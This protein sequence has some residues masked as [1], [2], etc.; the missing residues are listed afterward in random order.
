MGGLMLTGGKEELT[1]W[2]EALAIPQIRKFDFSFQEHIERLKKDIKDG[3]TSIV[4]EDWMLKTMKVPH[5]P[6]K[7]I[8]DHGKGDPLAKAIVIVQTSWFVLQCIARHA[9]GLT[10][11]EIELV[12]LAF[13]ALNVITYFLW[14]NKPL[15][16][17][18]PIYINMDGKRVDGPQE[19]SNQET[20]SREW[21]IGIETDWLYDWRPRGNLVRRAFGTVGALWNIIIGTPLV[22]I[23]TSL[24]DMALKAVPT[25]TTSQ[26]EC[27]L[28][29]FT[30]L[31]GTSHS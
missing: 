5:I 2:V 12:T 26:L 30:S 9:R 20:W 13:A 22:S 4:T 29:E 25:R 16:A 1:Q 23:F 10:V 19:K 15:N 11:T 7:E 24:H 6:E 28:E 31:V 8:I 3:V 18:Y 27:Y 14:W 21:Y 17:T